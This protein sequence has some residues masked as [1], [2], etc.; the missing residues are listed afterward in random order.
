MGLFEKI[1][2]K[3]AIQKK[4]DGYFKTLNAYT[5]SFTTFGGS[6]YEMELTRAAIDRIASQCAK[7]LPE[8]NGNAYKNLANKLKHQ[9]NPYMNTYQFLYRVATILKVNTTA[10]IVPLY[11][12]GTDH[13]N[14][15]YPV[16]PSKT[17]IVTF[18]E[19]PWL[20]YTFSN[21]QKA[22]CELSKVGIMTEY[23]YKSDFFGDGNQVLLP[24]LGLLDTQRQGQMEAIK[25][26]AFIRFMARV[27]GVKR[28]DD[29]EKIRANFAEK[30]LSG[31][32]SKG[33]LL[34]DGTLADVKQID[35]KPYV[36]DAEQQ[37]LIQ[38]NV[39]N[40]FGVSE[41][42]LQHKWN[43]D[44]WNAFYEGLIEPFAVQL[45]QC[46]TNMLFTEK[47]KSFG[48][49][50]L[51]SAN[52]MQYASNSTKLQVSSQLFDRGVLTTNQVMD[53]WN[54]PHVEG[55]DKRYIRRE[56]VEADKLDQEGE[57]DEK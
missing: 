51:L 6:I 4:I 25:Q 35:S 38:D 36:V 33:L 16:L 50:V 19:E 8:V 42:I 40:Y 53:I 54:L 22:A 44:E 27:A 24:T 10:F 21:G 3:Q 32:N 43:E 15:F 31:D 2:P 28:E 11:E 1:F 30:N 18:K 20:R 55:G 29:L 49:E 17:E 5:P 12:Y 7:L 57:E 34:F 56:Y 47:E 52:R 14:G 39:F 9:P 26:S 41:N 13:I 46:L 48:N 23:Q 37:K 45:S